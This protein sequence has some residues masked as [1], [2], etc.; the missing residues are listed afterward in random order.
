[1]LKDGMIGFFLIGFGAL[2]TLGI[3]GSAIGT[4]KALKNTG[5]N[6]NPLTAEYP[7]AEMPHADYPQAD[8]PKQADTSSSDSGSFSEPIWNRTSTYEDDDDDLRRKGYE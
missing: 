3:A 7:K 6:N 2:W 8:Y 1:M 4:L 5:K